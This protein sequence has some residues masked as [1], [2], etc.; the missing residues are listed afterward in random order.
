MVHAV[1]LTLQEDTG[2]VVLREG[3]STG[4]SQ[5]FPATILG[6]AGASIPCHGEWHRD[7]QANIM[8]VGI[9]A[10][11]RKVLCRNTNSDT[12]I[13]ADELAMLNDIDGASMRHL[14]C[15][16]YW[17]YYRCQALVIACVMCYPEHR[18]FVRMELLLNLQ[19]CQ[20]F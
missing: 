6:L 14:Y 11:H 1:A 12:K 20:V 16:W 2:E 7:V 10:W 3:I 4:I 19:E 8:S 15:F 18:V 17:C 5:V 13:S 9:A